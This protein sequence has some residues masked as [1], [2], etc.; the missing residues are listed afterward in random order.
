MYGDVAARSEEEEQTLVAVD[1]TRPVAVDLAR[2]VA[3]LAL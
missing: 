3:I 2:P 1:L